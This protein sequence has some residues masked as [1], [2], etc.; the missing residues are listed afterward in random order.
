MSICVLSSTQIIV[1]PPFLIHH[2]S[3]QEREPG[4]MSRPGKPLKN[5]TQ[6]PACI[7]LTFYSGGCYLC[8]TGE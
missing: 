4:K 1:N 8:G 5:K 6:L 3:N 7:A 2:V